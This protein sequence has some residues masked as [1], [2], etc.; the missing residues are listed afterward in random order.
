M[1]I[2]KSLLCLFIIM[3][4]FKCSI[5]QRPRIIY[6][7]NNLPQRYLRVYFDTTFSKAQRNQML[8]AL[9][10]YENFNIRIEVVNGSQYDVKIF[11]WVNVNNGIRCPRRADGAEILGYQEHNFAFVDPECVRTTY[12][13]KTTVMHEVGHF[14]GMDHICLNSSQRN[15][16]RI[17]G[18]GVAIMNPEMPAFQAPRFTELDRLEYIR[19]LNRY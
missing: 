19:S 18:E 7:S 15:C 9:I 11:N 12:R 8:E 16:H 2:I 17:F 13:F 3:L 6:N 14:L 10:N 4:G 1:K 5:G